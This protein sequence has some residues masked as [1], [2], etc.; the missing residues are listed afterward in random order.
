MGEGWSDFYAKDF[1]VSQWPATDTPAAGEVGMGDYIDR[2]DARRSA[3]R[4]STARS[5]HR[6]PLLPGPRAR[7]RGG[8]TYGDFGKIDGDAEVHADG[9][10]W[11][12]D[13]VGPAHRAAAR[14]T[15]CG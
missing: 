5:A 12:R 4:G 6:E 14:R 15:P 1:L 7:G 2:R 11:A 3:R 13:A 8:F 10:I 9:E